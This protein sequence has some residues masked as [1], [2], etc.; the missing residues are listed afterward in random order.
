MNRFIWLVGLSVVVL[1][2]AC[3]PVS[4]PT[5]TATTPTAP[6]VTTLPPSPQTT[7]TVPPVTTTTTTTVPLPT[8]DCVVAPTSDVEGYVHTC[9]VLG[10]DIH[11]AEEV[12]TA[13]IDQM[14]DRIYNMLVGRP[15]LVQSFVDGGISARVIADG[16]RITRLAE[17]SDLFD[18]YPGTDW[19]RRGRSF[20]G[21]DLIPVI[22]GAEE[23]LLCLDGDFYEGEDEFL[24]AMASAIRRFGLAIVDPVTDASIERAYQVAIASGLWQNTL[25]E[26]NSYEYWAEGVQSFFD[27]NLEEPDDRPANSSHNHVDTREELRAYD[28]DLHNIAI[29]VFGNTDWRPSCS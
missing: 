9:T 27:A 10:I 2:A 24:R 4:D 17:F 7:T 18:L 14:A 16:Q 1:V 28:P 13:A 12:Q 26:I 25:A 8:N 22:A 15:D 5:T 21:T 3:T 20:P 19:N 23:N 6:P 29:A 11:A